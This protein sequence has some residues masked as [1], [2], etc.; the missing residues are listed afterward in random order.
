M[1]KLLDAFRGTFDGKIYNHRISTTGDRIAAFL[2]DDLYLL[3]RSQKLRDRVDAAEEVVN[4]RNRVTGRVG[5]R[6][7]GT[8]GQ[9][10]PDTKH[11]S[12]SAYIVRR[13]PVA[14]LRI[15]TEVKI[16]GTKKLA[17]I[18]R[19]INDL[20]SQASTFLQQTKSAL[21]VGIAA[22]NFADKYTSYEGERA[23]PAKY[24]PSRDAPETVRR[25]GLKARPAYDEFLV[26]RFRATNRA[27]FPFEWVDEEE[28]RMQ[29][30]SILVRLSNA[31]E[32]R[33]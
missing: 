14:T 17:Q 26:L 10:V 30:N 27:P 1:S 18:D 21:T 28:T 23:F 12:E 20:K 11:R 8:F 32:E 29:Y 9:V 33:F 16:V 24:P 7:D 15:G 3:G 25:L 22:V 2:Y 13:G 31:Y 4:S 5:R 6:G 19:V